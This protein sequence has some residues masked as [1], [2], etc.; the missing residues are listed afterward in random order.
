MKLLFFLIAF[1]NSLLAGLYTLDIPDPARVMKYLEEGVKRGDAYCMDRL[2]AL[3]AEF[4]NHEEAKRY[5]MM[6]AARSGHDWA[7]RNL[8]VNYQAPGSVVSKD[9][10]AG[11]LRA[12]KAVNDKRKSEPREYAKRQNAFE[13]KVRTDGQD[14]GSSLIGF[15]RTRYKSILEK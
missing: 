6:T 11:T 4:G 9:D 2:G 13:E 15:I 7:M 8:M 10:L 1:F 5:L 12:H 14:L 3:T